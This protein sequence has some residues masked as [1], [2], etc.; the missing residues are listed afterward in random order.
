MCYV[1]SEA[2]NDME[3]VAPMVTDCYTCLTC[4]CKLKKGRVA[5]I[6]YR[7]ITAFVK[8]LVDKSHGN[9][10]HQNFL[11][12]LC[13]IYNPVYTIHHTSSMAKIQT[14]TY[15]FNRSL[16]KTSSVHFKPKVL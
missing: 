6:E 1:F 10:H 13:F 9:C 14:D 8:A 15:N 11:P 4:L 3:T 5:L 16:V 7:T 12:V 2:E